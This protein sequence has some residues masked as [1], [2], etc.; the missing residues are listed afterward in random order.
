MHGYLNQYNC[1]VGPRSEDGWDE[2]SI[3]EL[4]EKQGR[5]FLLRTETSSRVGCSAHR[6]G[7]VWDPPKAGNLAVAV[8]TGG[9]WRERESW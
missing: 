8:R 5:R 7:K 4:E 3:S 1:E 2:C 6:V 9:I